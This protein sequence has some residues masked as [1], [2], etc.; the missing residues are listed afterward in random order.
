MKPT[1]MK[2]RAGVRLSRVL[3]GGNE[4]N[5]LQPPL[6]ETRAVLDVRS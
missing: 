2:P 1:G 3:L 4:R 6:S 5:L